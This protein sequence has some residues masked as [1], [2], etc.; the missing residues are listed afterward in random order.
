M[1]STLA[2]EI[3][4]SDLRVSQV[5]GSLA[6]LMASIVLRRLGH[7]VLILESSSSSL[8]IDHGAGLNAGP[9]AQEFL[10]R[11][12]LTAEPYFIPSPGIQYLTL[13]CKVKKFMKLPLAMSSWAVLYYRLRANFDGL[14]SDFCPV[15]PMIDKEAQ[16]RG[17]IEMSSKVTDVSYEEGRVTVDYR[18]MK[19]GTDKSMKCDMVIAADGASSTIRQILVPQIQHTYSGYLAWRGLVPENEMS[20]EA[21]KIF[22][23][24]STFSYPGGYIIW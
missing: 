2:F 15:A 17:V 12:D 11:Y 23:T 7:D 24:F 16:G 3:S 10:A 6:G 1:H 9:F 4:C 18:D 22:S 8:R 21:M 20:E 19:K 5:G 14:K 13:D